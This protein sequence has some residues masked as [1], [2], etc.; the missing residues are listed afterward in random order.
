M[1]ALPLGVFGVEIHDTGQD[2]PL[3]PQEAHL[4]ARAVE[5]RRR[6]FTL[7]RACARAALIQLGSPDAVIGRSENCAPEWP[8]GVVGSITHTTGYACAVVAR[9]HT[10]KGLGIDA[11][12]L[13]GV[14]DNLLPR[15][16]N[17]A[18]CADLLAMPPHDRAVFATLGFSAKEA[19]YKAG[20]G[21]RFHDVRIT[22]GEGTFRAQYA[23]GTHD[24]R[25]LV[26]GD[27]ALTFIAI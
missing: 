7:G 11:E 22:W 8:A 2:V 12:I 9:Q 13:G 6:E 27:L 14:G 21:R 19:C 18:E 23:Q 24:G 3:H 25:F 10:F 20:L 4:V 16:F 15:L 17:Q 1:I 26:T 5:K